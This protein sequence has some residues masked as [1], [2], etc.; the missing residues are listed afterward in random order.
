MDEVWRINGFDVPLAQI[1]SV[2]NRVCRGRAWR[3]VDD[4]YS[5]VL[6]HIHRK[7]VTDPEFFKDKLGVLG[8]C[9]RDA[10]FVLLDILR[11]MRRQ[12]IEF[13]DLQTLTEDSCAES[14]DREREDL[15]ALLA[16]CDRA[17]SLLIDAGPKIREVFRLRCEGLN[18]QQ[19]ASRLTMSKSRRIRSSTTRL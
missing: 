17:A 2:V 19:V 13:R 6:L 16:D 1:R 12:P 11:G 4:V 3:H 18:N 9:R 5:E 15:L 10:R 14:G 8:F 7:H